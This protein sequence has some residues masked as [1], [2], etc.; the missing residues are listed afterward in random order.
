MTPSLPDGSLHDL[1]ERVEAA[2]AEHD[3]AYPG[4][5][6]GRQPV[7]T[8]YVPADRFGP[9]TA[10]EYGDEG[11]RL[12]A[13]HAPS[14]ESFARAMGMAGGGAFAATVRERVVAKLRR[15]PIE[16]LRIDFEDGYGER[17]DDE[18][19]RDAGSAAM[20]VARSRQAGTAPPFVGVRVKS[21]ADGRHRRSLRTLDVFL[22]A[23]LA[24]TGGALPDG[25][26]V[27]YPKVLMPEHVAAFA[28]ALG[29]LER[30]LGVADH[31]LRF[32]VQVETPESIVDHRGRVALRPILAASD[33]RLAGAHFGVYDYTAA[34]GLPPAEQ[35]IDHPACD[36]AR[37]VMQVTL[38]GTGVRLSDGSTNEV[39]A[40]DDPGEVHRVWA[41][42]AGLVRR[43]L[44][45]GF[46]QGWDLHPSHLPS[47]FAAV[48]GFLLDG[49]G[50]AMGRVRAWNEGSATANG[51]L[52]EPAT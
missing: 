45:H 50:A 38:A 15:E 51:V 5:P 20:A 29:L 48:Y 24:A 26:L 3:E 18:E 32:E 4:D 23:V 12:L 42:H 7:H 49:L 28:D 37:H 16:D 30:A 47:R 43:S 27:T 10:R 1:F 17:P 44:A 8:V 19:D 21:F 36:F 52:D 31:A 11:L 46:F 22:T 2:N 40:S 25:F 14:A 34:L 9:T 41:L 39:P 33:G 13:E 35:R 6:G